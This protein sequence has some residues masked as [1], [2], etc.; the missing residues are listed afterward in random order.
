MAVRGVIRVSAARFVLAGPAG[1]GLVVPVR[2]IRSVPAGV[3]GVVP[4]RVRDVV[5]A[6]IDLMIRVGVG[7][8]RRAGWTG[9]AGLVLAGHPAG[10][11]CGTGAVVGPQQARV[12][13]P[14]LAGQVNRGG[15]RSGGGHGWLGSV[16]RYGRA[17][18][19]RP[20]PALRL[21]APRTLRPRTL[22]LCAGLVCAGLLCA[23]L[24]CARLWCAG[25]LCAGL[26]CAGLWCAGLWCAGLL[27]AGLWCAALLG[28]LPLRGLGG[29]LLPARAL[30]AAVTPF[31]AGGPAR[32]GTALSAPAG[33]LVTGLSCLIG[34]V[35]GVLRLRWAGLPA[36]ILG[37]CPP[38]GPARPVSRCVTVGD[39]PGRLGS[40]AGPRV[41]G[42]A[43]LLG[44]LG[45]RRDAGPCL[46][47][48]RIRGRSCAA[49]LTHGYLGRLGLIER[50]DTFMPVEQGSEQLRLPGVHAEHDA[51]PPPRFL[52]RVTDVAGHWWHRLCRQAMHD[53]PALPR[54][55]ERCRGV[56]R[57]GD[58]LRITHLRSSP[59]R[60]RRTPRTLRNPCGAANLWACAAALAIIRGR[61]LIV[62]PSV[63]R[64]CQR[65]LAA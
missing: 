29:L 16:R 41:P 45:G 55:L 33:R 51:G 39:I 44:R 17:C 64:T 57:A 5:L 48:Q 12:R 34:Q 42:P 60:R 47:K 36:G 54:A 63:L 65:V 19:G 49:R 6:Q 26:L 31:P 18:V 59:E 62:P 14:V 13:W 24:L 27:C 46:L 21:R 9:R 8:V 10:G 23:G 22:L 28:T 32:F 4:V 53:A 3:S 52:D 7:G 40:R 43:F 15:Q 20:G 56:L 61:R 30:A 38:G 37:R 1:F 11:C 35:T 25:L 50:P 2:L 58:H